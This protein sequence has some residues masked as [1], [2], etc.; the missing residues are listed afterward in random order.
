MNSA[1]RALFKAKENEA[2]ALESN[3]R[4]NREEN[5]AVDSH[6]IREILERQARAKASQK[7]HYKIDLPAQ[8][9]ECEANYVRLLKILP[10]LTERD[11][12]LFE[13]GSGRT[14][15]QV[16]VSVVERAPYTT[17]LQL[18][19]LAAPAHELL[20]QIKTP[21]LTICLYHDADMAEVVAW[22]H[23]R[24]LRPRYQYP[25]THMYHIDEKAQCNRF[26]SDWLMLCLEQGRAVFDLCDLGL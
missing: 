23:H 14:Q 16:A 11:K 5:I 18:V 19:Q 3:S 13:I 20:S 22:E 9:A 10:D 17:T 25:N 2:K 6:R 24:R 12:W 7:P 26:L 21:K 1:V 8:L 15:S 4:D